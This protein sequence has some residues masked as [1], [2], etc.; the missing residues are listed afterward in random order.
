MKI[1]RWLVVALIAWCGTA[2]GQVPT[3]SAGGQVQSFPA[4]RSP[5]YL[6]HWRR[7]TVSVGQI[8]D[9]GN[10][11]EYRTVGSAVIVA[12][13]AQHGVLITAKH[14]VYNPSQGYT[15]TSMRIR[16]P[17]DSANTSKDLGVEVILQKDG[18]TLW[19]SLPD[20]SDLA[21]VALP[22][23]SRYPN[24]NAVGLQDFANPDDVY[25]G[26]SIFVLGYP[27]ILGEAYLSTPL[28]R[29]GIIAW[30]DPNGPDTRRFL[31]DANVFNGNS[32]G[33]VFH[34]RNGFTRD[35]GMTIGGG[36][37]F[38]GIVVEDAAENIP[39]TAGAQPIQVIDPRTGL[40]NQAIARVLNIGGIG[41]V[42][43][44][45]KVKELVLSILPQPNPPPPASP[46]V[47]PLPNP[48]VA[49]P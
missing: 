7:S 21:A 41:V 38:I 30:T 48:S 18:T 33:P 14:V 22:D 12:T 5:D 8:V 10:G 37:S 13:D 3:T 1:S 29:G 2:S 46:A 25:Q 4:P 11:P 15:P 47:T 49:K 6:E 45:S 34:S 20:G 16:L 24:I 28:A 19:K 42:E 26:A 31:I 35:G 43:P 40:T 23:L 9:S 44:S 27:V 32:G 36:V 17:Q 39:I